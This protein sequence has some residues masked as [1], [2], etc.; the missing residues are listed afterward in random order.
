MT[1]YNDIYL[2]D[3]AA[4]DAICKMRKNKFARKTHAQKAEFFARM[5]HVI[6][7][8]DLFAKLSALG[9]RAP[10]DVFAAA[11]RI[12]AAKGWLR[13]AL[14][15]ADGGVVAV[16]PH[17]AVV[18]RLC[19]DAAST[20]GSASDS[21]A[22]VA[23]APEPDVVMVDASTTRTAAPTPSLAADDDDDPFDR[24]LFDPADLDDSSDARG[25]TNES[26]WASVEAWLNKRNTETFEAALKAAQKA[27]YATVTER[28]Q[29]KCR[30]GDIDRAAAAAVAQK[31]GYR[32][33]PEEVRAGAPRPLPSSVD[34][35]RETPVV[36]RTR[37][38]SA[39][40]SRAAQVDDAAKLAAIPE[41]VQQRM[42]KAGLEA[43]YA[44]LPE[45]IAFGARMGRWLD[46]ALVAA[47]LSKE[48]RP[49]TEAEVRG[50][51]ARPFSH[52]CEKRPPSPRARE[53]VVRDTASRRC[54]TRPC[55]RV[56]RKRRCSAR[57]TPGASRSCR[58]I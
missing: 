20:R 4:N 35:L 15:A 44:A 19:A 31:A 34:G 43:R 51:A 22:R 36:A 24:V 45:R 53:A 11:E 52:V 32:L 38:L 30:F 2:G 48:G 41:P 46:A 27:R 17:A 50:G 3:A 7:F 21:A 37:L 8:L 13:P 26:D 28:I 25:S 1:I 40:T 29:L 6:Y 49:V 5:D 56:S 18:P 57:T 14:A 12:A 47:S 16:A 55:S 9:D 23:V 10:A 33:A 39:P 58:R 42:Y 54:A